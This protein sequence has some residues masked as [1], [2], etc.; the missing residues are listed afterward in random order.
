MRK[1]FLM[2]CL[3]P[4]LLLAAERGPAVKNYPADQVADGVYVIHGPLGRPSVENQGFMNNPAFI[5][6]DEGVVIV[7]P[8]A[9]VQI[10]E[11]VLRQIRKFTDKPVVAVMNTHIHGDHWLANQAIRSAYPKVAIYGHPNM[12]ARIEEGEGQ[13]WVDSLL[14]MTDN[15]TRGTEVVGPNHAIDHGGEITLAGLRIRFLFEPKAHS[16]SDLMIEIPSKK[17]LFLGDNVMANRFGQMRHGTFKGNIA[18]IDMALKVDAVIYVPGHGPTG[19]RD[20]P[21]NY[22]RYLSTLR[23][24]VAK[25][26]DEGL[27]D[28]E[29]KPKVVESLSDYKN[30]VDFDHEVGSHINIAYLEVEAEMFE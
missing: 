8:G 2:V 11:M 23:I 12:I 16:D 5:V 9:S 10:G 13:S 14:S 24:E 17:L 27:S 26:L 28:Y 21:K 22:Q 30:W 19:G 3:L 25:W 20:V 29:M 1:L 15:A 18:A 7:D 4:A 6:T